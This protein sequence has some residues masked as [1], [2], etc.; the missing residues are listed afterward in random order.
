MTQIDNLTTYQI[1]VNSGCV[2]QIKLQFIFTDITCN[3]LYSGQL[4]DDRDFCF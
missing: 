3:L 4:D 1:L 2:G